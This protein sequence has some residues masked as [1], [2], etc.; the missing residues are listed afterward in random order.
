VTASI[1]QLREHLQSGP[2]RAA[3]DLTAAMNLA[4][5]LPD[6]FAH[7]EDLLEPLEEEL[8]KWAKEIREVNRPSPRDPARCA[9]TS[10]PCEPADVIASDLKELQDMIDLLKRPVDLILRFNGEPL[11]AEAKKK[12]VMADLTPLRLAL[13]NAAKALN[14]PGGLGTWLNQATTLRQQVASHVEGRVFEPYCERFSGDFTIDFEAHFRNSAGTPWWTYTMALSGKLNLRY[15][16]A[17]ADSRVE[18]TGEFSGCATKFKSWDDAL[19]VG[20]PKLMAG[21]MIYRTVRE[22]FGGQPGGCAARFTIPVK[23]ELKG[24]QVTIEVQGAAEKDFGKQH[25]RVTYMIVSPLAGGL[26]A[27]TSFEL[28][29]QDAHFIVSRALQKK[30]MTLPVKIVGKQMV[31]ESRTETTSGTEKSK[32]IY[33]LNARACNPSCGK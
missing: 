3:R 26:P 18:L 21:A 32:G 24:N 14:G 7:L 29:Y 5:Q 2:D 1:G 8:K 28:P 4:R 22:P 25:A 6:Q 12:T 9:W 31:I 30:A 23:G 13:Q 17:S 19:R 20:W 27:S 33:R 10:S 15:P 11:N 16:K